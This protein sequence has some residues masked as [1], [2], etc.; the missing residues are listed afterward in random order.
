[1][2]KIWLAGHRQAVVGKKTAYAAFVT[3]E[4]CVATGHERQPSR[5][6]HG[7]QYRERNDTEQ[8]G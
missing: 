5:R 3:D 2:R 4:H 7:R 1:M 8:R 6:Q